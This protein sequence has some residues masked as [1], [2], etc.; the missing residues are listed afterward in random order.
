MRPVIPL[1]D[2]LPNRISPFVT[3]ALVA[4]NVAAF[5]WQLLVVG[6]QNSV[7]IGGAIPCRIL[8]LCE[9]PPGVLFSPPVTL[10]TSMFLHGG[11]LH[12]AGNMLFLWVFGPHLEEALGHGR[13]LGFYLLAG[14]AA[15]LA[16]VAA[17]YVGGDLKTPMIG[18]SGA[19]SGVLAGYMLLFPRARVLTLIPLF[20]FFPLLYIPAFFFIGGWFVVQLL[21]AI[22]G[23][24]SGVAFSAHVGGFLAG[25]LL[26][27]RWRA[28]RRRGWR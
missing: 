18:A 20:L 8:M 3:V 28:R 19:I 17:S 26:V 5:L 9:V 12:I 22:Y 4:A 10:L 16:Q 27:A 13:F 2:D 7:L 14:I 1:R 11:F 25:L 6:L 24:G 21:G 23:G 15:A